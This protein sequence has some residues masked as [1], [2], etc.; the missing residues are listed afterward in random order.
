MNDE[1]ASLKS[2]PLRICRIMACAF[3]ADY[4]DPPTVRSGLDRKAHSLQPQAVQV[5]IADLD[6]VEGR[7]G[8][9]ILLDEEMLDPGFLRLRQ[10]LLEIDD[11]APDFGEE[12]LRRVVHVFDVRQRETSRMRREVF[13]RRLLC[14]GDPVKIKLHLDEFGA[15]L[16]EHQ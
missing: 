3:S 1:E 12:L 4:E 16:L 11:A 14:L 2:S 6:A 15:A 10:Q 5:I 9:F 8:A 13:R 7:A